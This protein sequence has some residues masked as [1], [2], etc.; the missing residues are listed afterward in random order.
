VSLPS[1]PDGAVIAGS[2]EDEVVAFVPAH[3]RIVAVAAEDRRIRC[4][5]RPEAD[6]LP[7]AAE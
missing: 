4:R 1:P 6:Q 5:C 7:S 3:E 2:G